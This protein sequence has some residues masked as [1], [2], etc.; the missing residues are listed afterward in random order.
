VVSDK[1]NQRCRCTDNLAWNDVD[2]L[3]LLGWTFTKVVHVAKWNPL[4]DDLVLVVDLETGVSD[5]C[6]FL[7][8]SRKVDDLVLN[9]H[10]AIL[11]LDWSVWSFQ[12]TEVV[13]TSVERQVGHQTDVWTFWRTDRV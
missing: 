5:V 12:E 9:G 10:L 1:R 6:I 3:H 4:L 7:V 2:V 13:D 8:V 11:V